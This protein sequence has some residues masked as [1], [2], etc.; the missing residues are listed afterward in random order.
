[1]KQRQWSGQKIALGAT[2]IC[3]DFFSVLA[4]IVDYLIKVP[5]AGLFGEI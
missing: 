2:W 5:L 1:L 3:L 4:G